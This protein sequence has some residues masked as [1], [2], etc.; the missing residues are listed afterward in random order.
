MTLAPL[1]TDLRELEVELWIEGD[2]LR[3]RAPKGRLGPELLER[4]RGR[5][6]ELLEHVRRNGPIRPAA[7]LIPPAPAAERHPLS[8]DQEPLWFL[9]QLRG[10]NPA[11][12]LPRAWRLEGPLDPGALERAFESIVERHQILRTAFESGPD[13]PVQR[14][15]DAVPFELERVDLR[16]VPAERQ[17]VETGRIL[18]EKSS[19]AFDLAAGRPRR[20]VLVEL[21]EDVRVLLIAMHHLVGDGHSF[22]VLSRELRALY[23]N[24]T[25]L[26]AL[27]RQYADFVHWRRREVEQTDLAAEGAYWKERLEG[28]GQ[29]VE[30]PLDKP[31]PPIQSPSGARTFFTVSPDRTAGL[32]ELGRAFGRAHGRGVSRPGRPFAEFLRDQGKLG[33]R[34]PDSPARARLP[35]HPAI[36]R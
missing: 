36:L 24:E 26:P 6:G 5:K 9:D 25:P 22:A 12:H 18:A 30:L 2:Q 29:V 3:Y 23:G 16:S 35:A 8:P 11:D 13:G 7:D 32:R 14:V 10:G 17:A 20:V 28:Y 4:L 33:R 34:Q 19:E 31:R 21:G 27:D 15:L 1:L